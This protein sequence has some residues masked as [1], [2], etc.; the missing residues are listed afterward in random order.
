MTVELKPDQERMVQEQIASGQFKSVDEVLTTALSRLPQ[1]RRS[2]RKA[3]ERMLEFSR[4]HS[5][6]LPSGETVEEL[7]RQN[8]QH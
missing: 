5:V 6:K 7:V 8:R 3:V 4:Q 1:K 2:N